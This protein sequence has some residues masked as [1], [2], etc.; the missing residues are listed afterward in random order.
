[1]MNNSELKNKIEAIETSELPISFNPSEIL[2][3]VTGS[4][5]AAVS[6]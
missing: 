4:A 6:L 1:M 2:D 3:D 5:T